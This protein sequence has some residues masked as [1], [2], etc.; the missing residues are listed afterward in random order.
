MQP[1]ELTHETARFNGADYD[2]ER[3]NIRLTSQLGRVFALMRD[4]VE[5]SLEEIALATGDPV[6]SI[7]AQLRH[8]RKPRFGE[9]L[10]TKRHLGRGFYK[11]KLIVNNQKTEG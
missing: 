3:D 2:P 5:R 1:L 8:L 6:T 11:Y 10:V 9:H 4:G 7:S